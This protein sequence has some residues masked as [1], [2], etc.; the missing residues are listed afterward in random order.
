M[1]IGSVY[2]FD[3]KLTSTLSELVEAWE[4]KL[5]TNHDDFNVVDNEEGDYGTIRYMDENG[6]EMLTKVVQAGD[7]ENTYLTEAGVVAMRKLML[8]NFNECLEQALIAGQP[9]QGDLDAWKPRTVQV[10]N[11]HTQTFPD[12]IRKFDVYHLD[13]NYYM[14]F[15]NSDNP[16]QFLFW[17]PDED[18]YLRADR[19]LYATVEDWRDYLVQGFVCAG[20]H[21][22]GLQ[23]LIRVY[24]ELE[25]CKK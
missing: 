15:V 11:L 24:K 1:S 10:C 12:E 4:N 16:A 17:C 19:K 14:P 8:D 18:E 21:K 3:Y 9:T 2:Y 23:D 5:E 22:K 6:V 7:I 20:V 25:A 13:G